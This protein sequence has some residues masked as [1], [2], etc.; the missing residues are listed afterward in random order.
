MVIGLRTR[1]SRKGTVSSRGIGSTAGVGKK[2]NRLEELQEIVRGARTGGVSLGLPG[3][4]P[5][6]SAVA[7]RPME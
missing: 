1:R 7:G 5:N 4:F 3:A 6:T 2:L